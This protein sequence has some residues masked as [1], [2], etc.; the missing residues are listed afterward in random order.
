MTT[1]DDSKFARCL[2]YG[3]SGYTGELIVERAAALGLRPILAGRSE[4]K[5]RPLAER[6]GMPMRAFG[7]DDADAL[8]RGLDGVDVVLH[9]AG[10]FSRTSRPMV[11][12]CLRAKVHYLDITGEVPVF[13]ACA[14]RDREAQDAGVMLMP[15]TGF[16]VVP[17]D[18]LAKHVADRLPGAT[19]LALAFH[20]VGGGPSH[21]TASTMVE[22]LHLPNLV[23]RGG[24]IVE[25]PSGRLSRD[26]DF[27]RGA[28][29]AL[30]IPWG[31]VSTAWHST[32][33]PSI[34]VYIAVPRAAVWGAK[35]LRFAAPAL[36]APWVQRALQ[37]RIDPGGPSPEARRRAYSLMWAEA[38]R[39]D[40]TAVSRLRV[41]EGYTLTA[42]TSLAIAARVL[43]GAAQPGFRTPAMVF[44]ADF[45]LGF[46]GVTRTDE[47][48][49][50][51]A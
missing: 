31:D 45:I 29:P 26:I 7:L 8:A 19:H 38:R 25:V 30:G 41:P 36:G 4:S 20:S 10:P 28:R 34:E 49:A 22:S 43:D 21:G 11:D 14:A 47:G 27:G 3:A 5:L 35:A 23:R 48:D 24:A 32:S 2:V 40:E 13:E 33:I 44:G 15:G 17:S 6:Y 37:S 39:G 12:A 16:D 1:D 50:R 46:D 51:T 9:A 42:E 18:C